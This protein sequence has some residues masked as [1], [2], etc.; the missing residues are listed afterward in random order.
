MSTKPPITAETLSLDPLSIKAPQLHGAGVA[1][2]QAGALEHGSRSGGH[3]LGMTQGSRDG[4][5]F[6]S[7]GW[8]CYGCHRVA[9]CGMG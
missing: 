2:W 6:R 7:G 4:L 9:G 3:L 1:P 8:W 5:G